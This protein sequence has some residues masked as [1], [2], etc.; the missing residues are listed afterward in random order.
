MLLL[1]II[2]LFVTLYP[3]IHFSFLGIIPIVILKYV[4]RISTKSISQES[5]HKT[6]MRNYAQKK[7]QGIMEIVALLADVDC[8]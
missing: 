8:Q 4:R 5:T 2:K 6:P 3:K 1:F 7:F